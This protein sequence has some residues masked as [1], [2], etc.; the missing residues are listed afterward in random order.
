[1]TT[2]RL[3][4]FDRVLGTAPFKGQV[5]NQISAWWFDQIQQIIPSHLISLPDP[6]A[7]IAREVESFPI[8]IIV[9]GY[10]TG[11]TKTALWYRY[12]LGEREIYGHHFQTI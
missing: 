2:D 8:E 7:L 3:S 11:V 12:N 4:V 6:N 5:I 9:R 10:I 1:M